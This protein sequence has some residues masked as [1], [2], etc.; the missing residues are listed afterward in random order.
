MAKPSRKARFLLDYPSC[1]LCGGA[2][3]AVEIDHVPPKACFPDGHY[4]EGF[5]FPACH[6]CNQFSKKHDQVCGLYLP[7]MDYD[8]R[9]LQHPERLQKLAKLR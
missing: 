9:K 1:Y 7:L 8:E 3:A 6:P 2:S 4:P 5:E